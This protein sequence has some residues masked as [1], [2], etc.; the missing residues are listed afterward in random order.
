[1]DIHFLTIAHGH[2]LF[3]FES[4]TGAIDNAKSGGLLSKPEHQ[5][6]PIC[7]QNAVSPQKP[8]VI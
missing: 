7:G 4:K 1:M 2:Q 3:I 5:L 8:G 6:K